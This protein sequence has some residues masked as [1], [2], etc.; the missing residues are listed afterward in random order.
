MS[1]NAFAAGVSNT[2]LDDI[3]SICEVTGWMNETIGSYSCTRGCPEP[4]MY[5]EVFT[6]GWDN[7]TGSDI[8]ILVK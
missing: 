3:M 6:N 8:G 2:F 5:P 1:K 4:P 7:T